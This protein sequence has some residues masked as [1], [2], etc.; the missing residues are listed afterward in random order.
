I[1]EEQL[2]V[3]D[4]LLRAGGDSIAAIRM[5]SR[6]RRELGL[7]GG[8]R[9]VFAYR[10]LEGVCE[11]VLPR[12]TT[13]NGGRTAHGVLAGQVPHPPM[14]TWF[15]R[16]RFPQP[17]HWNQAFLVRTPILDVDRL[18]AAV[19]V[20]L[21]YHDALRLRLGANGLRFDADVRCPQVRVMDVRQLR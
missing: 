20:L 12:A 16:Q 10:T 17:Q 11:R 4:D 6:L 13:P 3:R 21:R 2:G 7:A 5:A 9:D 1:P 8:V 15:Q 14:Q 18:Q 19:G